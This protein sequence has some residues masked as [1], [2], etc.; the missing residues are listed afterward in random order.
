ML[1]LH[2]CMQPKNTVAKRPTQQETFVRALFDYNP[3]LDPW[4]PAPESGLAF[5]R[6]DILQVCG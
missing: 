2:A 1:T 6:G 4:I 5:R 3:A